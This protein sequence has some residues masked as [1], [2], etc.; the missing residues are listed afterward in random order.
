[1]SL[2]RVKKRGLSAAAYDKEMRKEIQSMNPQIV[3]SYKDRVKAS[4][5][6]EKSLETKYE[7][8][9][10]ATIY[11]I[12]AHYAN[13]FDGHGDE[14]LLSCWNEY[15]REKKLMAE[16]NKGW[17]LKK[18]VMELDSKHPALI[19]V[20]GLFDEEDAP[21]KSKKSDAP[22]KSKKSS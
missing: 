11:G 21:K 6:W 19:W 3:E 5:A 14:N 18:R 13:E 16:A 7:E 9:S 20:D 22:K 17:V 8:S 4:I 2:S 15:K 10:L 12:L 1:M